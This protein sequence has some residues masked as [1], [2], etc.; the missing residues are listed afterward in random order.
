MDSKQHCAMTGSIALS[1]ICEASPAMVTQRSLHRGV[2]YLAHDF[3]DDDGVHLTGHDRG[4]WLHSRE[5]DFAETRSED[6]WRRGGAGRPQILLTLIA[7]RRRAE[8]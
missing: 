5:V 4:A 2:A 7:M 6:R 8:L 1:S 3:G